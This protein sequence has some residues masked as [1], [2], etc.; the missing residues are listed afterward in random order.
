LVIQQQATSPV[1]LDSSVTGAAAAAAAIV[2]ATTVTIIST[3][4]VTS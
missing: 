1:E 3:A 2:T 4:I